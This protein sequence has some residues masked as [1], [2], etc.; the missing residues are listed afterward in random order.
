V[1]LSHNHK[2]LSAFIWSELFTT[3]TVGQ[4]R[5]FSS[6]NEKTLGTSEKGFG[7]TKNVAQNGFFKKFPFSS[8]NTYGIW[9]KNGC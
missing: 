6:K 7:I 5:Y 8:D 3:S 9:V 1:R 4:N 2:Q